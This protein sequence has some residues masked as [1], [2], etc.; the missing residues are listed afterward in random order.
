MRFAHLSDLHLG[1]RQYGLLERALDFS[2][3]F[4]DAVNQIL[5]S[6]VSFVLVS[7]DIFHYKLPSAMAVRRVFEELG[8]LAEAKIPVFVLRGNH[9]ASLAEHGGNYLHLLHDR[10][11]AVYL[12]Q[13]NPSTDLETDAGRVR[14]VGVGTFPES[15][16]GDEIE[17]AKAFVDSE[18]DFNIFMLHQSFDKLASFKSSWPTSTGVFFDTAFDDVD[19][20]ALGHIHTHN[21][22]HPDLPAWYPGSIESY[23]LTEAETH[24]HN[25][26]TGAVADQAQQPKGFLIVDIENGKVEVESHKVPTRKM[27]HAIFRYGEVDPRKATD[28]IKDSVL[29]YNDEGAIVNVT[30][31]GYVKRGCRRADLQSRLIQETLDKPLKSRVMNHLRYPSVL[32]TKTPSAQI[33]P[34][35]AIESYYMETCSTED[36]AAELSKITMRL[37]DLLRREQLDLCKRELENAVRS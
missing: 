2:K 18:A 16:I 15:Q 1:Y 9:D 5:T 27:I 3:A 11:L 7:G 36:A 21:L 31:E 32:K 25:M 17:K 29:K 34:E 20:Y 19:Y 26:D 24:I 4:T 30:V 6:D 13:G 33:T 8:R 28:E 23:D 12:E 14:I 10:K 22:K 37:F 35:K